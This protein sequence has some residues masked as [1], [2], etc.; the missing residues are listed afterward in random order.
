MARQNRGASNGGDDAAF[1]PKQRDPS[2]QKD[3]E[4]E[5]E[6][7]DEV[8]KTET[9]SSEKLSRRTQSKSS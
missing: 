4:A 8:A 7:G 3:S 6:K 1:L 2:R 5:A 9:S